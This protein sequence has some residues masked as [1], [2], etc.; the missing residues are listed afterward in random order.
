[1]PEFKKGDV[2]LTETVT[3]LSLFRKLEGFLDKNKSLASQCN[4]GA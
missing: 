2:S 4:Y 1:M 3:N